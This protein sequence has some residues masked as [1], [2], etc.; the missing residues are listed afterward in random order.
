MAKKVRFGVIGT[1]G[2]SRYHMG[3]WQRSKRGTLVAACDIQPD[4]LTGFCEQFGLP[5]EKAYTD[6]RKMLRTEQPD[7]VSICTWAQH[8]CQLATLA[9]K[10]GVKGILLEK[11]L[12]YSMRDADKLVRT[13]EK[14][15]TKVLVMHQRR[16]ST[17]FTK[18]RKLIAKGAIGQVHTLVRRAG[19]GLGNTHSHSIDMMRY[20]LGD[21]KTEW[22]MA[23]VARDTNRWER[24]YPCEDCVVG[25]IGFDGGV[26][27]IIDSDTPLEKGQGGLWIYGTEGAIDLFGGPSI[28]SKTTGGAWKPIE[29]KEVNPPVCYVR[30]LV[31]W[32]DGGPEPRISLRQAYETH[33]I[34]MAMYESART[35]R[36]VQLPLRNRGYILQQMIDDG[37]LPL[38]KKKGYDIRQEAAFKAGLR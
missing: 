1:G 36:L 19:G 8:H 30:D 2:I 3:G 33:H 16:Y 22:V 34:I 32:I 17:R 23:Q 29:A 26:R 38:K 20:V 7:C 28:M 13:A 35:H 12:G 10:A 21:P 25:V 27:G 18:A 14:A 24:C 11:P 37:L 31:K 6:V 4:H 5:P 9:A 15:G